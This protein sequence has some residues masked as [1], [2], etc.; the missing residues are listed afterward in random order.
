MGAGEYTTIEGAIGKAS[1]KSAVNAIITNN[2]KSVKMVADSKTI[3]LI[4]ASRLNDLFHAKEV[5]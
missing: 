4:S 1:A 5:F 3:F 2:T